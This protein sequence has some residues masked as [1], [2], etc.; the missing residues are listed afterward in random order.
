MP[1]TI[2]Q[3]ATLRADILA[4]PALTANGSNTVNFP[5]WKVEIAD[6]S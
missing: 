6:P 3:A 1:L 5:T 2:A 4:N